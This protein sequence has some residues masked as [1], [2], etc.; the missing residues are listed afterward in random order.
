ML[1]PTGKWE[2]VSVVRRDGRVFMGPSSMHG[3]RVLT[4]GGSDGLQQSVHAVV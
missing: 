2:F 4:Q 1:S 3:V